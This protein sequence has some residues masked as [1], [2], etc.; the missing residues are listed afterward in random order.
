MV[1]WMLEDYS[2]YL[3][4][5]VPIL[6]QGLDLDWTVIWSFDYV[7]RKYFRQDFQ[8]IVQ[9]DFKEYFIEVFK[10]HIHLFIKLVL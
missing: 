7:L 10:L 4:T 3:S 6:T 2:V 1:T 8:L 5:P 9:I